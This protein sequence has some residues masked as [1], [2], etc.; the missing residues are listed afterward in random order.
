MI[1][2]WF[3]VFGESRAFGRILGEKLNIL[4]NGAEVCGP[5]TTLMHRARTSTS[6]VSA[7]HEQIYQ[8]IEKSIIAIWS[9][10]YLFEATL[11]IFFNIFWLGETAKGHTRSDLGT[12]SCIFQEDLS[13]WVEIEVENSS[14]HSEKS[15]TLVLLLFHLIIWCYLLL[16]CSWYHHSLLC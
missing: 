5:H 10:L 4:G 6:L 14:I 1:W 15:R 16:C 13:Q 12:F 3:Q 9:F 2:L 8:P 7:A 11:D